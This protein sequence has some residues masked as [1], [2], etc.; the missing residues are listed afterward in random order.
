M[1]PLRLKSRV[2]IL[3]KFKCVPS[4]FVCVDYEEKKYPGLS[5]EWMYEFH[6]E[7]MN[8]FHVEIMFTKTN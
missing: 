2:V 7:I 6:V 5:L 4:D 1:K 3:S 8:E